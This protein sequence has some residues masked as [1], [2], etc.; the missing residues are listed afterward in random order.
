MQKIEKAEV[1]IRQSL[2][3][4]R[5]VGELSRITEENQVKYV[6]RYDDAYFEDI[7][8]RP[9]SLTL[10]KTEQIYESDILFPYFAGLVSEGLYKQL[11]VLQLKIDENDSFKL[12]INT[13]RYNTVDGTV[14]RK[15]KEK[16]V[17][18][19]SNYEEMP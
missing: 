14:F 12:L 17:S 9:I 1:H 10:P 7:N 16:K 8:A 3:K 15:I 5:Y 11:Q 6:F 19:K 4:Q 13:A 2:N 18:Q